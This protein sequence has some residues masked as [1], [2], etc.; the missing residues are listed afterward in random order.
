MVLSMKF[1]KLS[2]ILGEIIVGV[3]DYLK[4]FFMKSSAKT[5][6]TLAEVHIISF[7]FFKCI[8]R[9]TRLLSIIVSIFLVLNR[10]L[11]ILDKLNHYSA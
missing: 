11:F 3:E 2:Y 9:L 1:L 10:I 4:V 8:F 7:S 5:L 6:F